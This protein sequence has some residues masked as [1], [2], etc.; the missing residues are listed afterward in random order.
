MLI[1]SVD[2]TNFG[3]DVNEEIPLSDQRKNGCLSW[4]QPYELQQ[5]EVLGY[6][7]SD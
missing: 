4:L 2:D 1:K 3:S 7:S 5:Y 6:T